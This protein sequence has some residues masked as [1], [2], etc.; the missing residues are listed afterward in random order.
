MKADDYLIRRMYQGILITNIIS[1]V[2]G[3]GCVMV[4]AIVTGQ[5]LGTN[6]VTAT[7]LIQPV[8][9]IINLTGGLVGGGIGTVCTRYL[10][11][12]QPDR[13]NQVYS[14]TIIA[15]VIVSALMVAILACGGP[16]LGNLLGGKTGTPEIPRMIS[17]Y[18]LGYSPGL[19]FQRITIM[20][21]GIMMLD[22]DKNR[23]IL[24]MAA[25]LVADIVFDLANALVFHGGMMGMALASSFSNIIGF[26]VI[27]T[28]FLRKDRVIHFVMKGLRW[29]DL[30]DVFLCGIPNAINMGSQA[31]RGICFNSLLLAIAGNTAVA[32]LSV[33]NGAF[34]L[35]N[36]VTLGLFMSA[37]LLISMLYGEEDC[38]GLERGL[39]LA[40]K[41]T[42]LIFGVISLIVIVFPQ[43]VARLFITGS[44][45]DVLDLGAGF[46]RFM[47]IQ[48]LLM[49]VSYP[50]SGAWQGT[51]CLK[52]NYLM[53]TMR[54]AVFPIASVMALGI[55]FG[56]KGA[57]AGFVLTGFLVLALCVL[58]PSVIHRRLPTS[59]SDFLV[60][61]EGFGADPDELYEVS[62]RS[63]KDV[64]A[65]SEEVT[66][67][68][69]KK[70]ADSHTAMVLSLFVEE[71]AKNTVSYGFKDEKGGCI[72]LRLIYRPESQVVRLRDNGKP[73]DPVDWLKR[74]H[75]E[76]PTSGIGIRLITGLAESV[77]Y[78]S[79]MEM[80]NLTIKT[81][82]WT[83]GEPHPLTDNGGK[84]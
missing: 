45:K 4:D 36:A 70:G 16:V 47:M 65:A 60:L 10:G 26:L 66:E 78:L 82:K 9:M 43:P 6:A 34:S 61:P 53:D 62:M 41:S 27:M 63:M 74:N 7:G 67:F 71:M 22:N 58:I 11:K 37:A 31:L 8:I 48:Y 83:V 73:F 21:A 56:L 38:K 64:M 68:C 75:P 30:V 39:S 72:D 69:N 80:N 3:V 20:L 57:E 28:H 44:A 42:L 18:L 79:S 17:Q 84:V 24:A 15:A 33:C 29:S 76:D 52:L 49:V 2:S 54:E 77:D 12:A 40:I 5:F 25:T 19:I 81:G 51:N 35:I 23:S 13:V 32:A 14:I 46:I 55:L 1:V 59:V 50:L